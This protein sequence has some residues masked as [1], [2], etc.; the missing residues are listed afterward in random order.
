LNKTPYGTLALLAAN[1]IA[2]YFSLGNPDAAQAWGF[3]PAP[4]APIGGMERALTALT[5]M[6]LHLDPIHLLG[7][8]LFLA[9]V[10]PPVEKAAGPIRF[11][12][13]YLL[14]GFAG[15]LAHWG[16]AMIVGGWL[17]AEPIVGASGAIAGLVGYAWLRF[18]RA[19]VPALPRVYVPV[20][21]LILLWMIMQ[22]V[23]A[24]VVARQ[25]GGAVAFWA[26]IGGFAAGFVYAL[27]LGAGRGADDE[28]W[29]ASL[30][31]AG[32]RGRAA[33]A[34]TAR[35]RL[36][37]DP[38]DSR[39]LVALIK[40]LEDTD[41]QSEAIAAAQRLADSA[42]A[43]DDG[44]AIRKLASARALGAI[45]AAKRL[46]LASQ[47]GP[48]LGEVLLGSILEEPAGPETAPAL[49]G[50]VELLEGSDRAAARR[51]AKRLASEFEL[52][53]ETVAAKGR[54]PDLF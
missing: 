5:S 15:V 29:D 42:P 19:K 12:A 2:A 16:I 45:R 30:S 37:A 40:S 50:L 9:A 3:T 33:K 34:A 52:D 54:W 46:R 27:L 38:K 31:E 53:P 22:A 21:S 26:H 13:L 28:V 7:N 39:A 6:F 32:A 17:A 8:M 23:G 47:V 35:T 49:A 10:G 20:W 44:F 24:F 25:Y 43:F 1:F 51:Y 41:Q 14:V 4:L 18:Y 11:L 48:E 36:E